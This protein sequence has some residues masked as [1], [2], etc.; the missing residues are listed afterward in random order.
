MSTRSRFLASAA[1]SASLLLG[2][3]SAF[4]ARVTNTTLTG[5]VTAVSGLSITI[6][7]RT[8]QV[9]PGS[10]AA[11]VIAQVQPGENVD[12]RLDGPVN[13][14]STHIVNVSPHQGS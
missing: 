9:A 12:V 10:Q 6:N 5:S 8:Y 3:G 2:A 1:V 13:S 7:G 4:A 11:S 14:P